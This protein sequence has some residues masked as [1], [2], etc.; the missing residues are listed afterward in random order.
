MGLRRNW[1]ALVQLG[2]DETGMELQELHTHFRNVCFESRPLTL[3]RHSYDPFSCIGRTEKKWKGSLSLAPFETG[4]ELSF[5]TRSPD[6]L[7]LCALS[8]GDQE[9]FLAIQM[10]NGRPYFL[11]D[12]QVCKLWFPQFQCHHRLQLAL[13]SICS[14]F[15]S[16][17]VG[18]AVDVQ[19]NSC[20]WI[21][22]SLL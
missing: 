16:S 9:E 18:L 20:S 11:F 3:I 1:R 21:W 2:N 22:F 6:G 7:L 5:R 13:V 14:I 15:L 17:F 4:V 19:I 12:P 8:P 10:K